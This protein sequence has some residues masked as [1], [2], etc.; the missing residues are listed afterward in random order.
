MIL[1][2]QSLFQISVKIPL[3]YS[4]G[5]A[6]RSPPAETWEL[7]AELYRTEDNTLAEI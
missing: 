1:C 6:Q 7:C 5:Q 4:S 2:V 3:G